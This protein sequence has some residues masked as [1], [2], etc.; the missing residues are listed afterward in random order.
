[1]SFMNRL[2]VSLLLMAGAAMAADRGQEIKLWSSGAPGSEG[3]TAEEVSKPSAAAKNANLPGNFTVTH[4]PS[5]YVFLPPKEK[6]GCGTTGLAAGS[7]TVIEAPLGCDDSRHA[8]SLAGP[9]L[10]P[11]GSATVIPHEGGHMRFGIFYECPCKFVDIPPNV[12]GVNAATIPPRSKNGG[13]PK[14]ESGELLRQ[15]V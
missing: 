4:Y 1:M 7:R 15:P 2:P 11:A 14:R 6:A 12:G 10:A 8:P 13:A 5:I 3:I 9:R